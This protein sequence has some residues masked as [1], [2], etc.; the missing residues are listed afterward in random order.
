MSRSY[1]YVEEVTGDA[2][3]QTQKV[4]GQQFRSLSRPEH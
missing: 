4:A 1:L 2:N 3:V